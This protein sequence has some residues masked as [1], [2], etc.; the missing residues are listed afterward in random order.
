MKALVTRFLSALCLAGASFLAA[1]QY[2]AKPVQL[3]VPFPAG[4]P[5][6][7]AARTVAQAMSKSLGQPVL[8]QNKPGADGAIAALA[9]ANAPAD[10]Y[11]LF[12][13]TSSTMALPLTTKPP[14]FQVSDFAPVGAVGKFAFCMYLHP[15]VPVKSMAEFLAYAR[16]NPGKLSYASANLTEFFV[17]AQY[18]KAAGIDMLRVPYK[19]QVQA[20]PDLL[21]GRVQVYITPISAAGVGYAKEGRLR[22]MATSER[23]MLAPQAPTMAEAGVPGVVVPSY[24]IILAPAKTPREVVERLSRDLN[25]ALKDAAVR[26]Q[27]ESIALAVEGST[28]PLALGALIAETHGM[29][30]EFVRENGLAPQ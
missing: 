30:A 20:L 12:F 4:G 25:L 21:E 2:P 10:G 16:A 18:M 26:A 5:T 24:K 8:V 15:G 17:G 28:S 1:A 19:G 29:W 6:D 22:M 27:L 14:A 3:V 23:S 11:T 13:T 7:T 9:V